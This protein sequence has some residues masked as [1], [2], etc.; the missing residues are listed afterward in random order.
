MWSWLNLW[1]DRTPQIT[2]LAELMLDPYYRSTE[3]FQV[4]VEKEWLDFGHKFADRNGS[5][6]CTSDLNERSPIFLQVSLKVPLS[7]FNHISTGW[8]EE[9]SRSLSHQNYTFCTQKILLV[10]LRHPRSLGFQLCM[11]IFHIHLC[12]VGQF[13][14]TWPKIWNCPQG[15]TKPNKIFI[16]INFNPG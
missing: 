10:S 6:F 2:A 1:W 13:V 16:F 15:Q 3:G 5:P 9:F 7:K 8:L 11:P 4:L 12:T 14:F